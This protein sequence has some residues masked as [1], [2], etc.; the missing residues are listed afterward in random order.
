MCIRDRATADAVREALTSGAGGTLEIIMKQNAA[1]A[2]D[3]GG[4]D[5]GTRYIC[6]LYTSI[7][8]P[9]PDRR[10]K[11]LLHKKQIRYLD[12]KVAEKG[13]AIVP[14]K[15][16]SYTHLDV[17]KRQVSGSTGGASTV[18]K[19]LIWPAGAR[20]ARRPWRP[21]SIGACLLYTSRCV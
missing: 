15:T 21:P 13:L 12:A 3:E 10:R 7:F 6:L 9:D 11:L 19:R 17:Y 8:N 18:S 14:L 4:R 2:P 5:F 20:S 1:Q 16:V